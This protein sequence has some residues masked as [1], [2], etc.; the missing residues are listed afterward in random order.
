MKL[1]PAWIK[2][3]TNKI[4]P[5]TKLATAGGEPKGFQQMIHNTPPTNNNKPNPPKKYMNILF[6]NPDGGLDCLLIP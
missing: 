1:N 6:N 5:R 3:T 4:T 2:N